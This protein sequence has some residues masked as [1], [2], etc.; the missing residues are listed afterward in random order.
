ME[1]GRAGAWLAL[2]VG[3][4]NRCKLELGNDLT[5]RKPPAVES[6]LGLLRGIHRGEFEVHKPLAHLVDMV[7]QHRPKL[8]AL[9][10]YILPDFNL[11][12][13]LSLRRRVKHILQKDTWGRNGRLGPQDPLL[14]RQR[15]VGQ[16][17][18]TGG[19]GKEGC[20]RRTERGSVGSAPGASGNGA[21]SRQPCHE[22]SPGLRRELE[23][24]TVFLIQFTDVHARR[25]RCA[26]LGHH[27]EDGGH[28]DLDLEPR[29]LEVVQ[30]LHRLGSVAHLL[31]L[32][33]ANSHG[34]AGHVL[35]YCRKVQLP[36][37]RK[38][39]MEVGVHD[40][41]VDVGHLQLAG[42]SSHAE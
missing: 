31:V 4:V 17:R 20:R 8:A 37:G 2:E 13:G 34:A 36:K 33:K 41:R 26:H 23:A 27:W 10:L 12:V 6:T 39:G 42:A 32:H 29:D 7:V 5:A 1:R 18:R 30:L 22:R 9:V 28:S 15:V 25:R 35:C 11:P 3:I 16:R 19:R 38:D 24:A 21:Y 40:I 14:Q